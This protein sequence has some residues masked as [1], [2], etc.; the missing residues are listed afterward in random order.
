MNFDLGD[1]EKAIQEK[2]RALFSD[3]CAEPLK[4]WGE[5][6]VS[7]LRRESLTWLNRLAH[8]GYLGLGR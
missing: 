5:E 3:T 2:I 8:A 6:S 4:G 1:R 7:A